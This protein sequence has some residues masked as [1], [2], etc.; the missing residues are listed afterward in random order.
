MPKETIK[1]NGTPVNVI[2]NGES[3]DTEQ[4]S[5]P[6]ILFKKQQLRVKK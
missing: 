3:F 1:P 2:N 5:V 4:E 6:L